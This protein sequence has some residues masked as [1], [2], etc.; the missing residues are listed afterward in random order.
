MR[1]SDAGEGDE[2]LSK[3]LGTMHLSKRC[4]M[5]REQKP[6]LAEADS[7]DDRLTDSLHLRWK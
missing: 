3:Y 1:N 6:V 2:L 4:C 7:S 5:T